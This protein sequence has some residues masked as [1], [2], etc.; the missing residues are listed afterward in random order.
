MEM[1]RQKWRIALMVLF[2]LS[3]PVTMFY[4]SPLLTLQGARRG[5]VTSSLLFVGA[6]AVAAFF[7][8]GFLR[9]DLPRRC[10][11]GTPHSGK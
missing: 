1:K 11:S 7:R 2:V 6:A 8:Q 4:L 3:L 5:I 10:S 9:M